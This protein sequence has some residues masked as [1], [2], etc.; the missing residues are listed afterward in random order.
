MENLWECPHNRHIGRRKMHRHLAATILGKN[1]K[2]KF[3]ECTPLKINMEH[4]HGG[5]E[6]YFPF[7][8][9]YSQVLC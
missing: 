5:L 7:P 1:P 6:D 9:V 8:G 2:K 3:Q 4:N